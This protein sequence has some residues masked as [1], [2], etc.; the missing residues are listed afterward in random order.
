MEYRK[1]GRAG[2]KVSTVGMG[3]MTFGQQINEADSI[4][5][6]DMAFEKWEGAR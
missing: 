3:T 1:V 6:M 4:K 5:I 2:L